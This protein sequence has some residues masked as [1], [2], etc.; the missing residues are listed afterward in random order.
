MFVYCGISFDDGKVWIMKGEKCKCILV[1]NSKALNNDR[2]KRMKCEN[3][4]LVESLER[5][6]DRRDLAI[7][8]LLDFAPAQFKDK[9]EF[10]L[11]SDIYTDIE[12]D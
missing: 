9:V 5:A 8:E 11:F 10:I 4:I 2:T 7:R 3:C 1:N 6:V 12:D